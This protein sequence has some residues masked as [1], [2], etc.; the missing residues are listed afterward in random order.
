S[1]C[2]LFSAPAKKEVAVKAKQQ[3]REDNPKPRR[4]CAAQ[5][6]VNKPI[7]PSFGNADKFPRPTSSKQG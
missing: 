1:F 3:S 5:P 2:F 7:F 6:S 4:G